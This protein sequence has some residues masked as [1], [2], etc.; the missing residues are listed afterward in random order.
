MRKLE[1]VWQLA[2]RLIVGD[3]GA[4]VT[5]NMIL[6]MKIAEIGNFVSQILMGCVYVQNVRNR[7]V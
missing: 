2:T 7:L 6:I 3:A 4:T 1:S 5:R